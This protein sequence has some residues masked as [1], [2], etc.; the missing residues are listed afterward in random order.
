MDQYD[1]SKCVT[2]ANG[3]YYKKNAKVAYMDCADAISI[4]DAREIFVLDLNGEIKSFLD[5]DCL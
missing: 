5:D 2:R 4:G 1:A 3:D